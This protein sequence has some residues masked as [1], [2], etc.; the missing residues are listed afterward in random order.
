MDRDLVTRIAAVVVIVA[1]Y[2]VASRLEFHNEIAAP[3]AVVAVAVV[4]FWPR[5]GEHTPSTRAE[6]KE[7]REEQKR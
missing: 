4:M 3:L 5:R 7:I 2:L 6:I 1:A